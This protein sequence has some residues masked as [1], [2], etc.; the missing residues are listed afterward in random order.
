MSW[1]CKA[2]CPL[3]SLSAP[4]WATERACRGH[5]RLVAVAL[6][7]VAANKASQVVAFLCEAAISPSIE[8]RTGQLIQRFPFWSLGV[9][10]K[11]LFLPF[12]CLPAALPANH[13][14]HIPA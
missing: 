13:G 5:A 2:K 6:D 9:W 3:M 1:P 10:E 14:H 12:L 4:V 8:A 11:R 7:P